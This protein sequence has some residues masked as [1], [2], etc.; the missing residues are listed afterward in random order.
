MPPICYS[1]VRGVCVLETDTCE[2]TV[3]LREIIRYAC[4]RSNSRSTAAQSLGVKA[5]DLGR[6][7]R[8]FQVR[9]PAAWERQ[10]GRG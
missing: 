5:V 2:L 4:I 9:L 7:A 3:N 8:H 6:L 10:K 1:D